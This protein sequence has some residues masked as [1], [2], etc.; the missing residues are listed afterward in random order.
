M[1]DIDIKMRWHSPGHASPGW[2][3]VGDK[4]RYW[5]GQHWEEERDVT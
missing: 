5:N 2:Y 1:P 4:V 3:P